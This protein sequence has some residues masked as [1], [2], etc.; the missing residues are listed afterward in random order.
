MATK[1]IRSWA[2]VALVVIG[3]SLTACLKSGDTT[4]SRPVGL[5]AIINGIASSTSLDL[6]DNDTKVQVNPM[7]LGFGGIAYPIYAGYH[8]FKFTKTGTTVPLATSTEPYDSLRYYTVIGFGDSTSAAVKVIKDD[9]TG[10]TEGKLNLRFFNLSPN[11]DP[12]DF[13]IGDVKVDSNAVYVGNA[14][15]STAFKTMTT[16]SAGSTIR[17]KEAGGTL[18]LA[19]TTTANLKQGAVY[20]IYLAGLKNTPTAKLTVGY[21]QSYY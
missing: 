2:I 7:P 1:T 9:F 14:N 15:V 10:A 21:V 18:V 4:P 20:T 8:T 5:V 16:V 12:V 13:Y 17:V 11:S 6:Y 3:T 19:E